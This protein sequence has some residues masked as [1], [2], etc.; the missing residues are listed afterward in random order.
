MII[1]DATKLFI[2]EIE[3]FTHRRFKSKSK[4]EY[5]IQLSENKDVKPIFEE[6]IFIAK[7]VSNAHRLLNREGIGDFDTEKLLNEYKINIQ[8]ASSLL[9]EVISNAPNDVKDEFLA[10]NKI[11]SYQSLEDFLEF[12]N[13]LSWIKNYYLDKKTIKE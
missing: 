12:M 8:K 13:E 3:Q 9:T 4:I 11:N 7:F 6:L 2:S 1:S 5:L 10:I